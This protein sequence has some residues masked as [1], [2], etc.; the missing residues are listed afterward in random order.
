MARKVVGVGSVGTRCLIALFLGRDGGDPLVLQLK[1]ANASV[2]E[3]YAGKKRLPPSRGPRRQRPAP[4]ARGQRRLPRLVHPQGGGPALLLA[5]AQ[6]HEGLDRG[7]APRRQGLRPLR[8]R[9]RRCLARAHARSG[10]P[11]AIAAYLGTGTAFDKA[12]AAFAAAYADQTKQDWEAL[13]AAIADGRAAGRRRRVEGGR[14]HDVAAPRRLSP[15]LPVA[16]LHDRP[17]VALQLRPPAREHAVQLLGAEDRL[18]GSGR[19]TGAAG[20]R[21]SAARPCR[22]GTRSAPRRRSPRRAA[23]RRSC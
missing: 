6:G 20:M 19:G 16:G 17:P 11:V 18:V 12:L 13:K 3:P 15:S 8:R 1:E 9:L 22:R 21:P 23:R 2:L 10:D 5:P 7:R 4:R 14:P